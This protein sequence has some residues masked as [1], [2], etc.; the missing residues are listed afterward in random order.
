MALVHDKQHKI[1]RLKLYN[2]LS[3]PE[4][5]VERQEVD[6]ILA[7]STM[8]SLI[9]LLLSLKVQITSV[10]IQLNQSTS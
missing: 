10:T 6:H 4:N 7:D 1:N 5:E 8:S 9:K 3:F 2:S